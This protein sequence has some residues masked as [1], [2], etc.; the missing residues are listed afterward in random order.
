MTMLVGIH[1][2][3]AV[4]IAADK[5]SVYKENGEVK[6][7]VSD[8]AMKIVPW[9]GG[10]IT[11]SGY[12]DLL[13]KLKHKLS[14]HTIED[15][16]QI[17]DVINEMNNELVGLPEEIVKSTR[18]VLSFCSGSKENISPKLTY[19]EAGSNVVKGFEAGDCFVWLNLS[20]DVL[21][22]LSEQVKAN[23][24]RLDSFATIEEGFS[25]YIEMFE[26]LFQ[27]GSEHDE[28]VCRSYEFAVMFADG[29][30][31]DSFQ[32]D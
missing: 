4:F 28:T 19:V 23:I 12:V 24:Q 32:N 16:T 18:W 14:E 17:F 2:G 9:S 31:G 13:D 21:K 11:G 20:V 6:S 29:S 1:T 15:T 5:R 10:Y 26:Q 3:D 7:V 22:N 25:H 8:E 30:S 27:L